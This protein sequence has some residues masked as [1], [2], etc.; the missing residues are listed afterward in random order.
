MEKEIELGKE[1]DLALKV[2][3]GKVKIV[4]SADTKGLG[5]EVS[6]SLSAEYFGQ[7]LADAIP[8]QVDDA[9][10]ALIVAALKK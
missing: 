7:K 5:A 3:D 10:I 8:G 1:L 2:E 6:V 4:L 9:V